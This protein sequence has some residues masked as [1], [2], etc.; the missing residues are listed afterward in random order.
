MTEN[1]PKEMWIYQS[2]D[3][4]IICST[5]PVG[6]AVKYIQAEPAKQEE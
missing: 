6:D 5:Y 2:K 4:G 1:L 3:L